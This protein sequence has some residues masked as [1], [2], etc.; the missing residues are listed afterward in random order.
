MSYA[1]VAAGVWLMTGAAHA[2]VVPDRTRVIFNEGEQA[3]IVTISNN[4][5]T[6]PYLVQSWLSDA[7]GNQ[8]K[9]PLIVV[10]PLER[11]E[12]KER[13]ILRIAKLPGST[14][15]TDRESVFY[16]NIREVPPRPETSGTLQIAL[17]TQMKLFYRPKDVQPSRDDDPAQQMTLRVDVAAHKLVL[18][19]PTPLHVTVVDITAGAQKT[20]VPLDAVMVSPMS[21][22]ELPF[23]GAAP[24]ALFVSHID[25]YGGRVTVEYAC[26][27][28]LC[29]SVKK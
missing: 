7:N 22:A 12:P 17:H 21:T 1:L 27:A 26:D 24:T 11:I 15:P 9:T 13:N 23:N 2:S 4:S 25:D 10:P 5:A 18:D 16:L 8:I 20:P 14:L 3:A 29:R 28:N 19:N 6:Y